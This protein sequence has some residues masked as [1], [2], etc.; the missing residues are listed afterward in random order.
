MSALLA[1]AGFCG[2]LGLLGALFWRL[3]LQADACGFLGVCGAGC[4]FLGR[5]HL[6]EG[7]GGGILLCHMTVGSIAHSVRT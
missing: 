3:V 5:F 2:L 6:T 7:D 1:P 4:R